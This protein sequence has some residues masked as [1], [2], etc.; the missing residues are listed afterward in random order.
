MINIKLY[1]I[2]Y[3]VWRQ[4]QTSVKK[5]NPILLKSLFLKL[6]SGRSY[7]KEFTTVHTDTYDKE[8]ISS[9]RI[10]FSQDTHFFNI[11]FI[12]FAR[13]VFSQKFSGNIKQQMRTTDLRAQIS[14]PSV[15]KSIALNPFV[16]NESADIEGR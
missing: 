1:D 12:M 4:V 9:L 11:L 6:R 5:S 13:Y 7:V 10:F 2:S 14:K 8:D 15:S 16:P 3:K